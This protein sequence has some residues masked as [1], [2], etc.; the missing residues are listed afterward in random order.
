MLRLVVVRSSVRLE[1]NVALKMLSVSMNVVIAF[2]SS[3][4][5]W[6]R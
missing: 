1:L 5:L 2:P 4:G 3:E 6:C